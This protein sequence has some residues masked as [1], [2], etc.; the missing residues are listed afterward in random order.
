MIGFRFT[1]YRDGLTAVGSYRYVT[2]LSSSTVQVLDS[3]Q[4]FINEYSPYEPHELLTTY[5]PVTHQGHWRQ[6]LVRETRLEDRL[7]L[8]DVH[9]SGLSEVSSCWFIVFSLFA[10]VKR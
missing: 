10:E 9:P 5:D 6:V 8:L 2:V 1:K 4:E 3:L 7:L